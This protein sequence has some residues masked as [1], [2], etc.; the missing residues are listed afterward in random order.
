MEA[1]KVAMLSNLALCA[2]ALNEPAAAISYCDKALQYNDTVAKLWF[3]CAWGFLCLA[4]CALRILQEA[5]ESTWLHICMLLLHICQSLVC[6]PSCDCDSLTKYALHAPCGLPAGVARRCAKRVT[7]RRRCLTC[8]RQLSWTPAWQLRLIGRLLQSSSVPSRRSRSR[9]ASSKTSSTG[10]DPST[11][12][13]GRRHGVQ[14]ALGPGLAMLC[15]TETEH[16]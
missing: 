14:L 2:M 12:S 15:R 9:R 5:L 11:P 3:R 1:L 10:L 7:M 4:L 6:A 8:A 16:V 13:V